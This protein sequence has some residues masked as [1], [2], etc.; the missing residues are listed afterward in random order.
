MGSSGDGAPLKRR[1]LHA[2]WDGTE[3]PKALAGVLVV[4]LPPQSCT[5]GTE[6]CSL[7]ASNS[8]CLRP[9]GR[10][11]SCCAGPCGVRESRAASAVGS[12]RVLPPQTAVC[13]SLTP[14]CQLLAKFGVLS[15][16]PDANTGFILSSGSH[17]N[18][19]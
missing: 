13:L 15:L 8:E 11:G 6:G 12:Q 7:L 1:G 18:Y 3:V 2:C 19:F 16:F 17:G 14:V 5:G 4:S 10:K 9:G